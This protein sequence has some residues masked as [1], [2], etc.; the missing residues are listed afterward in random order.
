MW[1]WDPLV[2][3]LDRCFQLSDLPIHSFP[4]LV[5]GPQRGVGLLQLPSQ[6]LDVLVSFVGKIIKRVELQL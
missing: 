6:E 2:E 4:V 5:A 3:R 1:T